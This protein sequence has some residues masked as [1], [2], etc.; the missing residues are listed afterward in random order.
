MRAPIGHRVGMSTRDLT[1]AALAQVAY[2]VASAAKLA[3][4]SAP[5]ECVP[6]SVLSWAL[7]RSAGDG[8][9]ADATGSF[10]L[11]DI[12]AELRTEGGL[13][14]RRRAEDLALQLCAHFTSEGH[15]ELAPLYQDAYS[16]LTAP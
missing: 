12:D 3:T 9:L 14:A 15:H 6:H 4:G 2:H 13:H 5:A 10:D 11:P 16:L 7:L 1:D 8:A